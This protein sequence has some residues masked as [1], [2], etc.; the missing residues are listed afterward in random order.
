MAGVPWRRIRWFVRV[1]VGKQCP[2]FKA[3]WEGIVGWTTRHE[4]LQNPSGELGLVIAVQRMRA[5]QL[6]GSIGQT[7]L[8]YCQHRIVILFKISATQKN[9]ESEYAGEWM[10]N[11]RMA[12]T[13]VGLL[14]IYMFRVVT[15]ARRGNFIHTTYPKKKK[16]LS[17]RLGADAGR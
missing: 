11:G 13:M 9:A 16:T 14:Y 2:T 1:R 4:L 6:R 3:D 17:I 7:L 8:E 15:V 12:S 10:D 5:I